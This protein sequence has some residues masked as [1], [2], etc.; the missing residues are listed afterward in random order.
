M[1]FDWVIVSKGVATPSGTEVD[2]FSI[3]KDGDVELTANWNV[4]SFNITASNFIGALVG[5]ADTSGT[6]ITWDGETSQ[7][8]LNVNNS[9]FLEGTDLGT[10]TDTKWCVYD[11]TDTEIDCD[12]EPVVDTDTVYTAGSN[13]TL[14]A[15]VFSVNVAGLESYF[16]GVYQ[17]IGSYLTD[18]V[19][20]VTPTLGGN[21][22]ADDFNITT[23]DCIHFSS[24]GMICDL[25]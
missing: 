6:A 19:D 23:V 14:V 2:P 11:L 24:G 4:G 15:E 20:D 13:M 25:S 12:V 21:L 16:D 1:E 9:N 8:D 18:L 5:N 10:L 3:H 22:D 17:A 7:S